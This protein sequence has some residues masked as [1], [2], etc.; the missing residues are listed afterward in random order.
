MSALRSACVLARLA[1]ARRLSAFAFAR[2]RKHTPFG[3]K[4]TPQSPST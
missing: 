3:S 1:S 2:F 4:T